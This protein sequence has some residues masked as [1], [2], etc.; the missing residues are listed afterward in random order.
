MVRT[1]NLCY[2]LKLRALTSGF[3]KE[4]VALV[5]LQNKSTFKSLRLR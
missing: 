2:R 5:D 1:P 3:P 4:R